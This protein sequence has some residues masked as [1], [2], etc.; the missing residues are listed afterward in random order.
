MT[1]GQGLVPW[2]VVLG[3]HCKAGPQEA[4]VRLLNC[5]F[6]GQHLK[7]SSYLLPGSPGSKDRILAR[8]P[9]PHHPFIASF[10]TKA[11]SGRDLLNSSQVKWQQRRQEPDPQLESRARAPSS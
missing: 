9:P 5:L 6:L 4:L 1:P 2:C 10:D 7:H 8:S 11:F 3:P